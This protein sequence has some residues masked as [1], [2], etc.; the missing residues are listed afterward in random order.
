MKY[1][2]VLLS[3]LAFNFNSL[4]QQE[5]FDI[6]TYTPPKDWKKESNDTYVAFTHIDQVKKSWCQLGVYKSVVSKGSIEA[7][8]DSEWQDLVVAH[9]TIVSGPQKD[10]VKESGGWKS[11]TAAAKITKNGADMFVVIRVFSGYNTCMSI[12][13]KSNDANYFPAIE[14]FSAGLALKR[15]ETVVNQPAAAT[16]PNQSIFGSWGKSS[17]VH[18]NYGQSLPYGTIGYTKDQYHFYK[19]GTY[20]F[21]SKTFSSSITQLVLIKESGRFTQSGNSITV[22]PSQSVIEAWSKS[23]GTDKWGKLLKTEKRKLEKVTYRFTHHYFT[24]IKEWNLVLQADAET[25]RDG[26]YSGNKSFEN[27]WYFK[28]L[29]PT[30][31]EIELPDGQVLQKK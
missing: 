16:T 11:Q 5:T 21:V 2:S 29:S 31:P 8:F 25:E 23:K 19:D 24:G 27:A 3:L 17:S 28:T 9:N 20:R 14:Q 26:R 1:L 13:A 4:G 7:D 22:I 12:M 10:P 6:I 18:F 30:T 15:P